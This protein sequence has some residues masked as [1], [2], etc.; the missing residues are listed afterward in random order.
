MDLGAIVAEI[1]AEM[2]AAEDRG[3]VADY[4]PELGRVDCNQFGMAIVTAEGE[5]HQTGDALTPFRSKASRKFSHWQ[6]PWAVWENLCGGVSALNPLD[7]RSIQSC[8]WRQNQAS[9]A[10]RSSMRAH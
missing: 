9:R 6:L 4:I 2:A 3:R 8:N 7:W 10:I 1:G 5:T